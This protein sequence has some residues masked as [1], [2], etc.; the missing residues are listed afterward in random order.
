MADAPA[1]EAD[2]IRAQFARE[3]GTFRF[4]RW[5]RPLAP[6]VFGGD[7]GTEALVTGALGAVAGLAGLEVVGEDPELGRNALVF[8]AEGWD[9]FGEVPRLD[10]LAPGFARVKPTL[11]SV[12][13]NQFRW[14]HF[15]PGGAVRMTVSLIVVDAATAEADARAVALMEAAQTILLWSETA[16]MTRRAV[17]I[18]AEGRAALD[19]WRADLIR[20]AYDPVL[21]D[22]TEDPGLAGALAAR[23]RA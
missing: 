13:A 3:D 18:S 22:A 10:R 4:A 15:E 11:M 8:V 20:A 7:E 9:G 5:T 21:P 16:F 17:A 1:A 19:P 12:G 2:L 14:F 6:A 23:M